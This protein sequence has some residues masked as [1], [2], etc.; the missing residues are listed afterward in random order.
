MVTTRSGKM[1]SFVGP[2]LWS[3]PSSIST[4]Q[5]D[6]GNGSYDDVPTL[7]LEHGNEEY[8]YECSAQKARNFLTKLG[9]ECHPNILIELTF[10]FFE[11][12]KKDLR[13]QEHMERMNQNNKSTPAGDGS[14]AKFM[15]TFVQAR[16]RI[17]SRWAIAVWI[18]MLACV[19]YGIYGDGPDKAGTTIL[20]QVLKGLYHTMVGTCP[21]LVEAPFSVSS[22]L[23]SG[24]WSYMG[25]VE[26]A[27]VDPITNAVHCGGYIMSNLFKFLV[28]F[29]VSTFLLNRIFGRDVTSQALIMVTIGAWMSTSN[30]SWTA[31]YVF[32]GMAFGAVWLGRLH[33][34]FYRVEKEM[35]DT[36]QAGYDI[37]QN[38]LYVHQRKLNMMAR[39]ATLNF[40]IWCVVHIAALVCCALWQA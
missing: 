4:P 3:S 6:H 2:D 39:W 16:S 9:A 30:V 28:M 14:L 29:G 31:P 1:T 8:L 7:V 12:H 35:V 34:L 20:Y 19:V 37:D 32:V 13:H 36:Y 15:E 33:L 5:S 24:L 10:R 38:T 18:K 25:L 11:E 22:Y 40:V 26:T 23:T 21:I 27:V 17:T